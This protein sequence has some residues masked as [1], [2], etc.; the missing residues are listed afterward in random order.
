MRRAAGLAIAGAVLAA[1]LLAADAGERASAQAGGCFAPR[2]APGVTLV[3]FG[4]GSLAGLERCAAA[5]GSRVHAPA[6]GGWLTLDPAAEDSGANARFRARYA[7]GAAAGT[8]FL[9]TKD[10]P[11]PLRLGLIDI[12]LIDHFFNGA[13]LG[14]PIA[15]PAARSALLAV[16]HVNDAGGVFGQPVE[17]RFADSADES[18]VRRAL[19]LLDEEGVHAFV[20]PGSSADLIRVA[21]EVAVPRR[22]PFVSPVATSPAIGGLDDD[23]FVFRTSVSDEAQGLA[24]AALARDEGYDHVALVYRDGLWGRALAQAFR[25][26]FTGAVTSV[27]LHPESLDYADELRLLDRVE[28]PALVVLTFH[29]GTAAVLDEVIAR[30]RF[31]AFLLHND[32]RSLS[33]LERYP[34]ALDGA[35]GVAHYGLHLTEAEGH[36]EA[37]YAAEYGEAGH[38]PY[39]RETYDAAIALMLAAEYA[40]SADGA[41]I[42]DAL[43]AVA[44]PPGVSYPASSDGVARAL[45]AVRR[46]EDIDLDGEATALDWDARGEIVRSHMGVWR[47]SGG[48]IED[49]RHFGIDLTPGR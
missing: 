29:D 35:K 36:W 34:E 11:G 46:G 3:A 43:Y 49:L 1:A 6:D 37:D 22:V 33:L 39:M 27:A 40:G 2:P 19:R 45:A 30:G 9:L 38:A 31:D 47:F 20:G 21:A 8:L 23:G 48:A 4:G 14:G 7:D 12:R 41:A 44:A 18:A 13:P 5:A 32:H 42:R 15:G 10:R 28:A 26:H 17:V 16:R 25:D 24:L